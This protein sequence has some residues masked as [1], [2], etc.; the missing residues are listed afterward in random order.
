MTAAPFSVGAY[1]YG[2]YVSAKPQGQYNG[3]WVNPLKAAGQYLD[4]LNIMSYDAGP[5]TFYDTRNSWK[6]DYNPLEAYKAYRAIYKGVLN[7]GI[8][9]PPEAWGGNVVTSDHIKQI[10]AGIDKTNG[11]GMFT[12]SLQKPSSGSLSVSGIHELMCS[13]L[14][15]TGCTT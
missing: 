4:I 8:E 2:D 15:K 13:S 3:M 14:G 5:Y 6:G 10:A 12:W 1:Y 7:V 11:D 9:V